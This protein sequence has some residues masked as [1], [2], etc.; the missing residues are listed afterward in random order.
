MYIEPFK[1]FASGH[2]FYLIMQFF[3]LQQIL[4]TF[5]PTFS[6]TFSFQKQNCPRLYFQIRGLEEVNRHPLFKGGRVAG[7]MATSDDYNLRMQLGWCIRNLDGASGTGEF[8]MK[9]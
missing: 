8:N 4:W 3:I 6:P 1:A 7:T 9:W 2:F 5:S